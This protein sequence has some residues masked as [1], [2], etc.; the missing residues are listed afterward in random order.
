[1]SA[2]SILQSGQVTPTHL[3]IWT[4]D[5]VLQDGGSLQ[6][7]FQIATLVVT[8]DG[9]VVASP[10]AV[11]F[12]DQRVLVNRA[13]GF[14]GATSIILPKGAQ[15]QGPVLVK[16]LKGDAATNN[17]TVTFALGE[18]A[19]GL[20]SVVIKVAFGAYWFNPLS[21]GGYYLTTA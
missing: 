20:T 19:D 18:S 21:G 17:I 15:K 4:T 1:M 14:T 10:Y 6:A 8:V 3:A 5:G 2:Q 11:G 13:A 16:D 12:T 9:I 7:A